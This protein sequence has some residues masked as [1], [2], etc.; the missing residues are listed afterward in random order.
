MAER[1]FTLLEV[2]VALAVLSIAL[3]ALLPLF[4]GG[5]QGAAVAGD[6]VMA[7]LAAKSLLAELEAGPLM[8]G[9]TG[10]DLEGGG[11]WR[12]DVQPA[13]SSAALR[14]WRLDLTVERGRA[15]VRLVTLRVGE[16]EP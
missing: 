9:T 5:L 10:G 1:G 11:R 3:G 14:L 6:Q 12:L 15:A 13:E 8:P 16:V 4:A 2:L 7:T